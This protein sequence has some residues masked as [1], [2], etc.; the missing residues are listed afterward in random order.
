VALRFDRAAQSEP[1][2]NEGARPVYWFFKD[3]AGPIATVIAAGVAAYFVRQQWR[4]AEKQAD[5][6]LDQLRYSLFEKR[7]AIYNDVKQLLRL[8]LNESHN[9]QFRPFDVVPHYVVMDEAIFFF[10]SETC[11]WLQSV[12]QDC[13]KFLEANAS[14]RT[15]EYNSAE[16]TQIQRKLLD[17][18]Q[19]LPERF[20][21]E[22][23]FRQLTRKS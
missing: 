15:P 18:F 21:S 2:I 7:Y 9:E 4:T 13:Q 17:D 8:L 14:L 3:F 11:A 23:S 22:L 16:Y 20:R 1:I 19:A 12:Q 6:A 5:T 10:S